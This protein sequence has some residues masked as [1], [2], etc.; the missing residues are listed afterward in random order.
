M[1]VAVVDTET[2]GFADDD[3]AVEVAVVLLSVDETP[4]TN[5]AGDRIIDMKESSR[6]IVC[7]SSVLR[8]S[9]PVKVDARA[10][11]HITD[12]E[13]TGAP[14]LREL[15]ERKQLKILS[16]A[17]VVVGHNLEFDLRMLRQSGYLDK[18]LPRR[19]VC[20]WR[21]A[22]HLY[23]DAPKH[24]NQV[25]RYHLGLVP[26]AQDKPA[27]R[28]AADAL[29]TA[30]LLMAMLGKYKMAELMS[31]S[32]MPVELGKI[33]FGK[34]RG[35]RWDEVDEGY[36]RWVLTKDFDADVIYTVRK[37]LERRTKR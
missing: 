15:C 14:T 8:A 4:V 37:A 18:D 11:H 1:R 30:E 20:T 9:V 27:H 5:D 31:L 13:M 22:L 26:P 23:P 6:V 21:C 19:R 29:V 36:L 16:T 33:T 17:D 12:E 7:W 24:S 2:T 32:S 3:E 34:H 35:K 28:A 25:L 10:V